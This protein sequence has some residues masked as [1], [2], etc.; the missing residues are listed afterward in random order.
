MPIMDPRILSDTKWLEWRRDYA[1][2]VRKKGWGNA[3][4]R[5]W[6]HLQL[7]LQGEV[8]VTFQGALPQVPPANVGQ[9]EEGF[10]A[11]TT[12]V[13]GNNPRRTVP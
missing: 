13:F 10:A 1:N 8:L 5:Q 11:V 9:L 6:V 7:L 2:L 3:H 4:I 12:K